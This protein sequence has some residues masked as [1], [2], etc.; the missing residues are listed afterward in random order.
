[1]H[2]QGSKQELQTLMIYI[3]NQGAAL[4]FTRIKEEG[5]KNQMT[6]MLTLNAEVACS[7][8]LLLD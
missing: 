7:L 5:D 1:M 2:R 8:K 3:F 4:P 6:K